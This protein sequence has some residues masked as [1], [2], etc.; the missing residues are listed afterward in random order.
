M[1]SRPGADAEG[2][3]GQLF[4]K[5]VPKGSSSELDDLS[6][7]VK[8]LFARPLTIKYLKDDDGNTC[9]DYYESTETGE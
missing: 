8:E 6:I 5:V 9:Y 4:R 1:F 3:P 7:A 2:R